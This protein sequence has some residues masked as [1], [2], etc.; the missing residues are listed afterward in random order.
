M[1]FPGQI[2]EFPFPAT[3]YDGITYIL[4]R[5]SRLDELRE[6]VLADDSLP[7]PIIPVLLQDC[8]SKKRPKGDGYMMLTPNSIERWYNGNREQN[9]RIEFNYENFYATLD[10]YR[11]AKK[12]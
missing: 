10:V 4:A 3:V 2:L 1:I 7:F 8:D 9:F 6:C 11:Y 5:L 12:I